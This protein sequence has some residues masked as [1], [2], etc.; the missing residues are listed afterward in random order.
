[1]SS[2]SDQAARRLRPEGPFHIPPPAQPVRAV[3]HLVLENCPYQPEV[4]ITDTRRNLGWHIAML[5]QGENRWTADVRMPVEVT[6]L[7][8]YF[9]FEEEGMLNLM[10]RRQEEGRNTPIYGSWVEEPFKI[11]VYDPGRMPADWTKGMVIYQIFPDRFANGDPTKDYVSFGVY[12]HKPLYKKWGEAP[13]HPPLGRDFFGGDLRGVIDKLDYLTDLGIDCIYFTPIFYAATNHRYDAIDYF[14]I[15]PMLGTERDFEE[16]LE[17]AHG[18]GMKIVLDAVF[19]H[20][21]SD[22]VY[23]D[24]IGRFGQGA[25]MTKYSPYYRW[26]DFTDW[27]SEYRGWMG[28]G[29][30]PEFVECPEVEEFFVGPEGVTAYWLERGIDGWRCDVAFDNSDEFWRR[31]RKRIDTIRPGAYSVAELWI[32]A[33]HY[34]LGDTFSGAM[35]YRLGWALRGF[36]LTDSLTPSELD[37]RL[38]MLQRDTP[39]PALYSQMTVIDSHDTD[40]ILSV[41]KGDRQRVK[42][43]V[44]F[45]LAFPGAPMIYYGSETGLEG[46]YAEDGRRCMPWD[47]LDE[48]LLGYY[49]HVISLHKNSRALRYGSYETVVLDDERRLYGFVRRYEQDVVFAIFN[50]GDDTAE[51]VL[52]LGEGDQQLWREMIGGADLTAS[53]GKLRVQLEGRG[54]AWIMPLGS[55]VGM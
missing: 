23:F 21:S 1:M 39:E 22:S 20:C 3:A 38:M 10:E 34:M 36:C 15:D 28:L 35:N 48:D 5:P 54:S 11:A 47:Q 9:K 14:K 44:A 4:Y 52:P 7:Q 24:I 30:M 41:A 31:F 16:L 40:R 32:N 49:K 50:G 43:I 46:T 25:A 42:Q 27:P 26:F 37:D 18:R 33:T 6:I 2:L 17:K 53:S 12:G 51:V 45:H 8:Y 19:N 29:F 13:E 55:T